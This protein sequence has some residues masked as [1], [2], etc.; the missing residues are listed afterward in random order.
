[1]DTTE[2]R[3]N[4]LNDYFRHRKAAV[5]KVLDYMQAEGVVTDARGTLF[6]VD[7]LAYD[8]FIDEKGVAWRFLDFK[9]R[10]PEKPL[11]VE[12]V[13]TGKIT[14]YSAEDMS[15]VTLSSVYRP[16]LLNNP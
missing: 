6:T 14:Q 5:Q 3:K 13:E 16:D 1:M 4:S 12:Q 15:K 7:N 2:Y 10:I 11:I 8:T 9:Q